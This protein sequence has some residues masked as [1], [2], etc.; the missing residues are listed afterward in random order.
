M[1][2]F[3]FDSLFTKYL[4]N[5]G[6]VASIEPK[7]RI[8]I[9]GVTMGPGVKFSQGVAFGGIDLFQFLDKDLEVQVDSQGILVITG[10]Y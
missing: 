10:I 3:K 4:N 7:Q 8:R 9:G 5:D 6:T 1:A 2:R